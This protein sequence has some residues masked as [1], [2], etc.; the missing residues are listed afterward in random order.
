[1]SG[2][3]SPEYLVAAMEKAIAEQQKREPAATA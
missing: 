3:Q 2:A 1:V